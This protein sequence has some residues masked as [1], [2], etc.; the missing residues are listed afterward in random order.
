MPIVTFK[1]ID[2]SNCQFILNMLS[3][4]KF[5]PIT[6]K[7]RAI[8]IIEENIIMNSMIEENTISFFEKPKILN[9]KF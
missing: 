2:K 4:I 8:K 5:D 3:I 7:N 6:A 1:K 9:I